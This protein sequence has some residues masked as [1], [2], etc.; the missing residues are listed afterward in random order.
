MLP[1]LLREQI[2]FMPSRFLKNSPSVTDLESLPGTDMR[3]QRGGA[4][5]KIH[6]N[7]MSRRTPEREARGVSAPL[8][9]NFDSVKMIAATQKTL[10]K[11]SFSGTC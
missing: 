5:M 6:S 11:V 7:R 1:E 9:K 3:T 2:G 10:G 8:S 4:R